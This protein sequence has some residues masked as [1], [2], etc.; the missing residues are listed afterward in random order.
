MIYLTFCTQK[1][2]LLMTMRYLTTQKREQYQTYVSSNR[3]V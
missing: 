2:Q 1:H 3:L